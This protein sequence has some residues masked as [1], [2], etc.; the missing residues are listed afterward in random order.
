MRTFILSLIL[1][2]AAGAVLAGQ[3]LIPAPSSPREILG[4]VSF[5]ALGAMLYWHLRN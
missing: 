2:I 1:L 4:L 3:G 5:G